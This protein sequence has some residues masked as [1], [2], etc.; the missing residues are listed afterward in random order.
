MSTCSTVNSASVAVP[1]NRIRMGDSLSVT[2]QFGTAGDGESCTEHVMLWTQISPAGLASTYVA[3]GQTPVLEDVP[4]TKTWNPPAPGTWTLRADVTWGL[5][6]PGGGGLAFN[7]DE[8]EVLVVGPIVAEAVAEDRDLDAG[9]TGGT[10][11]ADTDAQEKV[12]GVAG[13]TVISSLPARTID[14]G[15]KGGN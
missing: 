8:V 15:V 11:D 2:E 1:R 6:P 3:G 9:V 12:G 7:G 10:A 14:G 13:R 4:Y 5:T